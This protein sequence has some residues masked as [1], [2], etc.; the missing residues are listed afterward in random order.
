MVKFFS[1]LAAAA[2]LSG[3]ASVNMATQEESAK[4]KK[5]LPPAPGNAGL[6][7][8]RDSAFG[9]ALKKDIWV[10]KKCLGESAS[11]VFFYTEVPGNQRHIIETESEFSPNALEVFFKTGEHHFVR[12]YI[13]IGAFV[14]G[15]N[16]EEI[17]ADKAK[18]AI[19]ALGLA[20]SGVCSDVYPSK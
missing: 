10:N 6:Y 4:A 17:E 5:F 9:A 18:D 15:A 8:Y 20:Q 3:C 13:K 2:I 14:G 1:A 16:L 11:Q 19:K 12:Q 7:V